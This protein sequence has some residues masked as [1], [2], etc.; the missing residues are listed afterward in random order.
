[1]L[2]V[3]PALGRF[4]TEDE[5]RNPAS[6]QVAGSLAV[7]SYSFWERQ[8]GR[9][10]N[11]L[12][13]TIV[14]TRSPCRVIGVAPRGFFGEMV[15]SEPDIWVPLISFSSSDNLENRRGQ[16]TSHMG[17]L[18]PGVSREEA[19]KKI[20]L[21]FQQ[22]IQ[23][24]RVQSPSPNQ[25]ASIRDF[26][27]QLEQ[28]AT[29]VGYGPLRRT[30]TRPLWIIMAIVALVLLIACA[31]VANLLLARGVARR[32]EI[33]ARLALG[34]SRMRLVRQ[35]LTE[36]VL[37]SAFGTIAGL[38][39]AYWGIRLL[40]QMVDTG[41]QPLRLDL[42]PDF[43]VL[44]FT[45]AVMVLTGIAFGI[46]PAWRAS[47]LDLVSAIKDQ[48]FGGIGKHGRQYLG[49]TLIAVQIALSLLLLIG[50]GLL[51]RSLYNLR[52]IDPGFR[53]AQVYVFDLAHN[54]SNR[55]PAAMALVAHQALE[56]VRQIPGIES[57]SFSG[58]LLFSPSDISAPL[59]IQ[60]YTPSQDERVSARFNSVSSG[61]IE[62]VGMKL[63]AGRSIEDRDTHNSPPVA[64]IN[65]SM[66]R[67]FFS[68]AAGSSA[69]VLGQT[70][71][72]DAGA[73]KGKR[74]EIV[75][76]VRDAKYN[77]LRAETKPMFYIPIE[78]L[79]RSLRSLEVRTKE[80]LA[81]IAEPVRRALLEV[82]R[83]VMIRRIITLSD[84][85]DRTIA[86]E[87]LIT[88]LCVVFGLLALLLASIGL[89]GVISYAVTQRTHEIGIRMALGANEKSVLW[90]VLR[91]S[92][93]IVLLG[94][95]AGL[96]LVFVATRLISSFLY[97]LSPLDPLSIGL[98]LML[99]GLVSL[100][101]CYL[102]AQRAT[103]VNPIVALRQE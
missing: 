18:K 78:Q 101:A 22:L 83:D 89:Y 72:I 39:V 16:F 29:G 6:S 52:S 17:R 103:R 28:G 25:T 62:T 81:A 96:S 71:E 91:Q 50:A 70:I 43:R 90:L 3:H 5:D 82:S 21:L 36:S 93:T 49:R 58:L 27:I 55:E 31:N 15:G 1:M 77:D 86:G 46:A 64:V 41:P 51:I 48:G 2:G 69:T 44:A 33:A 87:R 80:P 37:L 98:S 79:P 35:L 8:F 54:P 99:L 76:V 9:D 88:S 56:R 4:F 65:E 84:Q 94:I 97:G 66:A 73:M 59:K 24:E 23:D 42:T 14:I 102:P 61:Y 100:L 63:T 10:P 67:R 34:C 47:R 60:G 68:V 45:S 11:V 26:S 40:V 7:L 57:S 85:V 75:G 92:L 20:T 95:A 53:P 13:R 32:R 30:Y 38:I 12:D 19:E 74:I